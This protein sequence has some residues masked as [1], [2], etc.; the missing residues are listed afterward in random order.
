VLPHADARVGRPQVDPD[1]RPFPLRHLL[2]LLLHELKNPP[3]K[4]ILTI[5]A[6]G[7]G[8]IDDGSIRVG[9]LFFLER[10]TRGEDGGDGNGGFM[11]EVVGSRTFGSGG[12][13]G[14]GRWIGV[15][16]G[17]RARW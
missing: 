13:A 2:F 5:A 4:K 7:C 3:T 17:S 12:P 10:E 9:A 11:E 16:E 1:R 14:L 6:A 8:E 15:L